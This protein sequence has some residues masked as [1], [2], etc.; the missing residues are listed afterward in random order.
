MANEQNNALQDLAREEFCYLTTTGRVS[1]RP[2]QIEIWFVV[3]NNSIYMMAGNHGSDW[4]KNLRKNPNAT[5]RVANCHFTGTAR[6]VTEKQEERTVR[7]KMADKYNERETDGSLSDWAQTALP[8][9]IDVTE[10]ESY[11]Q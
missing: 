3:Q 8:V 5:V 10:G 4:V 11:V 1:G 2:H 9:A 7:D 6:L